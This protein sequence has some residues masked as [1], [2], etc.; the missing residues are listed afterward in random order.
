MPIGMMSF[1]KED[2]AKL[3]QKKPFVLDTSR[4]A[5]I[6]L[7]ADFFPEVITPTHGIL[8]RTTPG[9]QRRVLNSLAQV[10]KRPEHM[11]LLG[12]YNPTLKTPGQTPPGS[13]GRG[14]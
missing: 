1:T 4:I 3:G 12:P 9:F 6:P 14:R 8:K 7:N 13:S 10:L 5:Y 2:A 11:T